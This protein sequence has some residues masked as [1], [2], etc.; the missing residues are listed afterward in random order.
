MGI[1]TQRFEMADTYWT[2]G[3]LLQQS[4]FEVTGTKF[5]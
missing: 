5:K 4:T 2:Y 1:I 3:F